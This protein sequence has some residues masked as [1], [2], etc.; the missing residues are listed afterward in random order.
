MGPDNADLAGP[1][2]LMAWPRQTAM[3]GWAEDLRIK[4]LTSD[5]TAIEVIDGPWSCTRHEFREEGLFL[6]LTLVHIESGR[7]TEGTFDMEDGV[8][9]P[10]DGAGHMTVAEFH[11]EYAANNSLVHSWPADPFKDV[12]APSGVD[13]GSRDGDYLIDLTTNRWRMSDW[14]CPPRIVHIPTG[15]CLLDLKTTYWDARAEMRPDGRAELR[16]LQYPGT[17]YDLKLELDLR[18]ERYRILEGEHEKLPWEGYLDELQA[19]LGRSAADLDELGILLD[20]R[21]SR[22]GGASASQTAASQRPARPAPPPPPPVMPI[23]A[24]AVKPYPEDPPPVHEEEV[25]ERGWVPEDE[26]FNPRAHDVA[27]QPEPERQPEPPARPAS[28]SPGAQPGP[29]REPE[30][31]GGPELAAPPP[32][33]PDNMR[34]IA[35]AIA[36]EVTRRGLHGKLQYEMIV[37]GVIRAAAAGIT[38][39]ED[40][41]AILETLALRRSE[42]GG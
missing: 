16:L 15:D 42:I 9:A 41:V 2:Q 12:R 38:R 19:A 11:R 17:S 1:W 30:P 28:E 39:P 3:A 13:V 10:A 6:D 26:D 4:H 24:I 22:R 5:V 18:N 14:I 36:A 7:T 23:A 29:A 8:W 37:I 32:V 31:V 33:T 27:I 34:D 21:A 40:A 20:V 35:D 25:A